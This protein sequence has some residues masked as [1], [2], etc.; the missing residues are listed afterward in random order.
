MKI[1]A[2]I[3]AKINEALKKIEEAKL[4]IEQARREVL[5]IEFYLDED[6]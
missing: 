3:Q 6:I 5:S 2:K 4:V 1:D